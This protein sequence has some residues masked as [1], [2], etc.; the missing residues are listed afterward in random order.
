MKT[1]KRIVSALALKLQYRASQLV[2]NNRYLKYQYLRLAA[3]LGGLGLQPPL[4]SSDL[5]KRWQRQGTEGS[6]DR[7]ETYIKED[8]SLVELFKEVLPYLNKESK[9][10]E[11]GCNVGRSLNYLHKLGFKNLTGIEIGPK[12]VEMSQTVFP[13]MAGD[14]RL[15]VGSAPL[16]IRKIPTAE[17]DLVFCHSVL[18]NIHPKYNYIFREIAR[19]S[20]KMVLILENEGSLFAYPRDFKKLFERAGLKLVMS[21]LFSEGCREFPFPYEEKDVYINNTIQLFAKDKSH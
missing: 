18:V 5:A 11:L 20:K 3:I 6:A 21:K 19:V 1:L 16:E 7:P 10:L 14:S 12:A 17:Y 9:I 15:I 13:E 2:L 8:S 4:A